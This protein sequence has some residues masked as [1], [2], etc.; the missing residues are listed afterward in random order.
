[1]KGNDKTKRIKTSTD[2]LCEV[3]L[4]IMWGV[5]F[6]KFDKYFSNVEMLI[7]DNQP[8]IDKMLIFVT[9]S[10]KD[11]LMFFISGFIVVFS[12]VIMTTVNFQIGRKASEMSRDKSHLVLIT[13]VNIG[14]FVL[15]LKPIVYPIFIVFFIVS[16]TVVY[17]R[18]TFNQLI[19]LDDDY[20]ESSGEI[21]EEETND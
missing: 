9:Y 3:F 7:S 20:E 17:I 4:V 14:L 18:Q 13:I 16:Y 6:F 2:I 12:L 19:E 21:D 10:K 11:S 1:M 5:Y 8:L 15:L